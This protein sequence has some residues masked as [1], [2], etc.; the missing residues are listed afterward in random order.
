M[1][2][3]QQIIRRAWDTGHF[4]APSNPDGLAV[5]QADLPNLKITDPVV[6]AAI[7]SMT[8]LDAGQFARQTFKLHGREPV[9]DGVVGPATEALATSE[10]C[11]IPDFAPPP[12]VQ[13][14]YDDPL[15]QKAVE[16]MQ[17][18]A[19][20]R[21]LGTG[22]WQGCH[23]VGNFH[24]A[25]VLIDD[26]GLPSF[27]QASWL[28]V[29]RNTRAASAEVGLLL[30][31]IK[32]GV[33]VLTLKPSVGN[34]Q[35]NLSF[36]SS[37]SGWI[38]LAI[39]GQNETCTSSPIWCRFLN[40]YRGGSSD[41]A[42]ITQWTTLVMHELG[43][44]CGLNHTSGGVMNPSIVNGLP[45]RWVENDPSTKT[46]K[47]WFG[48]QPVPIPDGGPKDPP[49]PPPLSQAVRDAIQ[50]AKLEYFAQQIRVI[51]QKLGL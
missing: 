14:L 9:F 15:L 19:T 12:G 8:Q 42:I 35:I 37:S 10:R 51:N 45:G 17:R 29:L 7:Q 6:V 20:E 33:D 2:R 16:R 28:Q 30:N 31:F 48:G 25:N 34:I 26:S 13:F 46:L 5:K 47:G 44:N 11:S 32:N 22:S 41:A 24:A 27:L 21:S 43:H 1:T 39:L 4:W 49:V 38:G 23:G 3:D 36:V 18:N 40:T 50:D